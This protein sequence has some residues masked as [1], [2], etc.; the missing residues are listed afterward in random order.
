MNEWISVKD[1]L[2][3]SDICAL[4]VNDKGFMIGGTVVALYSRT[5]NVWR[6]YDPNYRES[7]TLEVSHYIPIPAVPP[8]IQ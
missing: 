7:V 2:P 1:R 3:E 6:L 5:Y 8:L 4:V